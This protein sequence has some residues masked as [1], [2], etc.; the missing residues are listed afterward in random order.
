MLVSALLLTTTL[1]LQAVPS[2]AEASEDNAAALATKRILVLD[3]E[4]PAGNTQEAEQVTN[5]VA[6]VFA[7]F[8]N[9]EVLTN[10]DMRAL[11]KLESDR[12]AAGCDDESCLSEIAD[13]MGAQLVVNGSV[14]RLGELY[15]V[16]LNIFDSSSAKSLGRKTIRAS[17]L[18]ALPPLIDAAAAELGGGISTS[19]R[20][21]G[22]TRVLSPLFLAG[23]S[24]GGAALATG[25]LAGGVALFA[26]AQVSDANATGKDGALW[27]GRIA[28]GI[29][30]IA[31]MA[32]IGGGVLAVVGL[33]GEE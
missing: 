27:A 13:A 1:A 29:G 23:A 16:T 18:E 33:V 19:K 7:S 2:S 26:N 22:E 25:A 20:S 9:I 17:S 3:F 32:A 15:L 24:L 12:Q 21:T 5:L 11:L 31:T 8:D 4:S 28:L 14:G 6:S 10:Q 30:A